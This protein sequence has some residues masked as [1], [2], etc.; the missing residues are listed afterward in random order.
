M[1]PGGALD[2]LR[3]GLDDHLRLFVAVHRD[4]IDV[5]YARTGL[6]PALDGHTLTDTHRTHL[7]HV[8]DAMLAPGGTAAVR[9]TEDAIIVG[10]P[11]PGDGTTGYLVSLDHGA[12]PTVDE[13]IDVLLDEGA[14]ILQSTATTRRFDDADKSPQLN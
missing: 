2:R 12:S 8:A 6:R 10:L 5:E 13:F 1:D 7:R 11:A 14:S 3:S 4:R 9:Y